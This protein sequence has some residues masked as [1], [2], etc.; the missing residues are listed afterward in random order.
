MERRD[1]AE[2]AARAFA[3][4][5][6]TFWTRQGLYR[7]DGR[8]HRPGTA[9]H[10]WPF[11]RALVAT[12]DFAGIDNAGDAA[13]NAGLA[14]L[15]RY[16]DT[17]LDPPAYSSDVRGT[18][19]GGD[20][21]YDDNAWVGLA[22]IQL[23]R[24][25]PGSGS[26]DRA[27]RLF[28]FAVSGWDTTGDGGVFWVEQGRG[29]GARNHDRNT[30]SN[31]PNAELGFHLSELSH[32]TA[33]GQAR[34]MYDWVVRTLD[35]TRDT[36]QAGTG[37]FWDKVQTDGTID[38]KVWTYNQGS[39]IGANVLLA[40]LEPPAQAVNHLDKAEAIAGKALARFSQEEYLR[41]PAA[42]NAIFFRNLLLLHPVTRD[43]SLQTAIIDA[44]ATYAD[45][46]WDRTRDRHD[47]FHLS[48]GGV[49]LL[50]QSAIVQLLALLAWDPNDYGKLA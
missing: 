31:A 7:R 12:L 13:I 36:D 42:F 50:N 11:S 48:H 19:I 33:K 45:E 22:L 35:E 27:A 29:I 14:A 9:A 20:R 44:I 21:Y 28:E 17:T 34:A 16:W 1:Y 2:R 37:L 6:A 3:A 39:M 49:T 15:E 38:K 41:Q 8:F 46:A 25:R 47:R 26:L 32:D 43:P 24:M 40:R 18:R 23:E 10:L 4:M 30:V 5:Q